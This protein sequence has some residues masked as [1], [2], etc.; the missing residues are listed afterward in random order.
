MEE[1]TVRACTIG[2]E[3]FTLLIIE[4]WNPPPLQSR[5]FRGILECCFLSSNFLCVERSTNSAVGKEPGLGELESSHN[6]STVHASPVKRFILLG[7]VRLYQSCVE[8]KNWS[9]G[10]QSTTSN[11]PRRPS[12]WLQISGGN[13]VSNTCHGVI[14]APLLIHLSFSIKTLRTIR[15]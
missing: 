9:S 11:F 10:D 13:R 3:E 1:T 6:S 15:T 2:L 4:Q 12:Y 14:S 8:R 5:Y 7:L